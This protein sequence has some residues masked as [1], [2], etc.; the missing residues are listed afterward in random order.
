MYLSVGIPRAFH[1]KREE[2]SGGHMSGD[3]DKHT[4]QDLLEKGV[5]DFPIITV[6]TG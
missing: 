2:K 3:H 5:E 6:D 1:W 4:D